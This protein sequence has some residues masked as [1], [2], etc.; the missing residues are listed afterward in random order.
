MRQMPWLLLVPLTSFGTTFGSALGAAEDSLAN[1]VYLN[2]RLEIHPRVGVGGR[3]DS[4]VEAETE[5][6]QDELAAIGMLGVATQFAWSEVTTLTADGEARMVLTDRPEDRWRNQGSLTVALN[7]STAESAIGAR[8]GYIRSDDPDDQT[9]ER[10]LVDTWS[11]GL[12]GDLTG[13]VHR[14]S[15]GLSFTR[16]DYIDPSRAFDQDARDANT[17]SATLGYG[18]K[19]DQGDEITVRAIGDRVVYDQNSSNQDST[20]A[21]G[22]LGWNRQV[23]E[24]IGLAI[25]GGAEY[26][27]YEAGAG[28]P[29]DDILSPTW[30]VNGRTVNADESTW[31]LTLSGGIE[32]TIDGNPA[33]ASRAGLDYSRPLTD[34]WSMGVGVEGFNLRDL[35]SNAGQAK[36][37]R[38]TVRG[39]LSTNYSFRP[40]LSGDLQGGY[41]YS[42]SDVEGDYDRVLV[43]A[44]VTARF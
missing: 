40:G 24:T 11:A 38:W 10:L 30:L 20:G 25:E 43:Q 27:R 42:D 8:A 19:L 28:K 16:S 13:L 18:L 17:Y 12:D 44:G 31:S 23:S 37:E 26:R 22:L 15:A 14:L 5:D 1:L 34:V 35:E 39:V 2:D 29:S 32:D 41:E 4:N 3:Y 6:P 36:D 21:H 9:G 33:L 7:R